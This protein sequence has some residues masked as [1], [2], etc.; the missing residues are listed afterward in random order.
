M[1][2]YDKEKYCWNI[3]VL[4]TYRE[5]YQGRK[6]RVILQIWPLILPLGSSGGSQVAMT[7]VPFPRRGLTSKFSGGPDGAGEWKE[8]QW[9]ERQQL[10]E[11][12][13]GRNQKQQGTEW[14]NCCLKYVQ[15]KKKKKKKVCARRPELRKILLPYIVKGTSLWDVCKCW[16]S[17]K[18]WARQ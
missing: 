8:H 3:S 13:Q 7:A 17:S 10:R 14:G 2:R 15:R 12:Q 11:E 1:T 18:L 16:R 4:F 5:R 6:L 9:M